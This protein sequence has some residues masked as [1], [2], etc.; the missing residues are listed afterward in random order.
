MVCKKYRMGRYPSKYSYKKAKPKP[1]AKCVYTRSLDGYTTIIHIEDFLSE[2]SLLVIKINDKLLSLEQ[3]YPARI[4]IPHLYGWK[5]TKWVTEIRLLSKY[6]D[7]Y[8][9]MLG[10]HERGNVLFEERFKAM[11]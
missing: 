11:R 5:G 2:D 8:W 6:V 10:Y 7:G 9:E 4:F 3:G 1:E